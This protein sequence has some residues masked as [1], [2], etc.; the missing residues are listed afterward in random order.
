MAAR[1]DPPK[2]DAQKRLSLFELLSDVLV[3]QT[4]TARVVGV[5]ASTISLWLHGKREPEGWHIVHAAV[6]E[7]IQRRPASAS[8]LIEFFAEHIFGAR[9]RWVP[10]TDRKLGEYADESAD[11]TVAHGRLTQA[12]RSQDPKLVALAADELVREAHEAD[13]AARRSAA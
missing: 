11:L 8:R 12:V 7:A 4:E 3:T 6:K 13:L 2:D 1:M 10:E 9:G 5:D